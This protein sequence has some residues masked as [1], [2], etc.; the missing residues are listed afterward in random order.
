[1]EYYH[2]FIGRFFCFLG[3]HAAVA[4]NKMRLLPA[5]STIEN[6]TVIF[7]A[8]GYVDFPLIAYHFKKVNLMSDGAGEIKL[9]F[10]HRMNSYKVIYNQSH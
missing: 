10:N 3:R 9:K 6:L 4:T 1:M 7:I 8:A 5:Y 2:G